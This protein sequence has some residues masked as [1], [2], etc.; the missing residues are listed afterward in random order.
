[1]YWGYSLNIVW[2]HLFFAGHTQNQKC[3]HIHYSTWNTNIYRYH[4]TL[5]PELH[6]NLPSYMVKVY[7]NSVKVLA[8][9]W[10]KHGKSSTSSTSHPVD[11][12]LTKLAS[13]MSSVAF[14]LFILPPNHSHQQD[15]KQ[16]QTHPPGTL[17]R[18]KLQVR[19]K[20]EDVTL[21]SFGSSFTSWTAISKTMQIIWGITY[22][23]PYIFFFFHRRAVWFL[24][25]IDKR[26]VYQRMHISIA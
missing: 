18:A 16:I 17:F 26:S 15:E 23:P 10:T 4:W 24:I 3:K 6:F 2:I 14:P 9:A 1:M 11:F 13:W 12:Y 7:Q 19:S 22:M 5:I 21:I 8:E 20:Y 25:H